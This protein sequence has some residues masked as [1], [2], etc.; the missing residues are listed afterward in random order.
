M[1]SADALRKRDSSD[2]PLDNNRVT[3]WMK[4]R[5]LACWYFQNNSII[6]AR[7]TIGRLE[8]QLETSRPINNS[9]NSGSLAGD[10]AGPR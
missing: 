2:R 1:N 3:C 4:R 8:E 5:A 10:F 6:L 7:A 9:Y